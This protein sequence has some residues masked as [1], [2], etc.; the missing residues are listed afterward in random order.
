[1]VN[2][3]KTVL[4]VMMFRVISIV[5]MMVTA[6][7][8]VIMFL[9]MLTGTL[10][11]LLMSMTGAINSIDITVGSNAVV[12]CACRSSCG[13]CRNSRRVNHE[14]S[15]ARAESLRSRRRLQKNA[16]KFLCGLKSGQVGSTSGSEAST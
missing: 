2:T 6:V 5:V 16:W 8:L 4:R 14:S 12:R 10:M 9:L 7:T 13:V 1:M 11:H 15:K 3:L